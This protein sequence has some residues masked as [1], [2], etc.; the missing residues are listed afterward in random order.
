MNLV[1]AGGLTASVNSLITE[2]GLGGW[3]RP[4]GCSTYHNSIYHTTLVHYI[5]FNIGDQLERPDDLVH[6]T[7]VLRDVGGSLTN[8]NAKVELSI[9]TRGACHNIP[10]LHVKSE[11]HRLA[12]TPGR[13]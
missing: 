4:A 8:D 9:N 5:Q 1:Q 6:S 13:T 12:Q 2:E 10:G 3:A 7:P 11:V